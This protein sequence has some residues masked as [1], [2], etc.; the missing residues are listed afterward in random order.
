MSVM[1]FGL[2]SFTDELLVNIFAFLPR[3]SLPKLHCLNCRI[4]E[5]VTNS[6]KKLRTMNFMEIHF[7][8]SL[9]DCRYVCFTHKDY[10]DDGDLLQN[11]DLK[12]LKNNFVPQH[13]IKIEETLFECRH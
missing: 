12:F 11:P 1:S 2:L 13:V 10:A 3:V 6:V 9:K 4:D 8:S 7:V 5:L